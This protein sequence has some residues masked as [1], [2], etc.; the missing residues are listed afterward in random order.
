MEDFLSS[1]RD[2]MILRSRSHNTPD[3]IEEIIAYIFSCDDPDDFRT[4]VVFACNQML[5]GATEPDVEAALDSQLPRALA[6]AL[7]YSN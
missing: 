6:K 7:S 1:V 2:Y 5:I 3:P 4:D